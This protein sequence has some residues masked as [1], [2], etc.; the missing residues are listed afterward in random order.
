[1][2]LNPGPSPSD[3]YDAAE[4]ALADDVRR[5]GHLHHI[6]GWGL[7]GNGRR[8]LVCSCNRQA[9]TDAAFWKHILDALA[10]ERGPVKR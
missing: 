10:K 4:A 3:T 1:M 2:T 6:E 8:F 7:L 9:R 5:L